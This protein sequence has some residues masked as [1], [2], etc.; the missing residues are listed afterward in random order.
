MRGLLGESRTM[1][2]AQRARKE[3]ERVKRKAYAM[4]ALLRMVRRTLM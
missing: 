1:V 3:G 4:V 2:I